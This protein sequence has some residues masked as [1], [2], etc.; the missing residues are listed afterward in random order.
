MTYMDNGKQYIVVPV[1]GRS[2]GGGWIAY[3]LP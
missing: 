2:Y 3:A 1:G